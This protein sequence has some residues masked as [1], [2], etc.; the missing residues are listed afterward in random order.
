[1][2][3]RLYIDNFRCFVNFEYRPARRQLILGGNGS[4]KSSLIEALT[5]L[6]R[7]AVRGESVHDMPLLDQRTRWLGQAEQTFE[8]D[9]VLGGSTYT[10]RLVIEPVFDRPRVRSESLRLG[11]KPLLAF[12]G[13]TVRL[14]DPS[15]QFLAY[16]YD[17]YRSALTTVPENANPRLSTFK[18]WIRGLVGFRMNPFAM[19]ALAE[20]SQPNPAFDLSNIAAWY[21]Y[22]EPFPENEALLADLRSALEGFQDIRL[23]QAEGASLLGAV[24]SD[25]DRSASFRFN[26]L[27]EG[28]R[29]LFC[30]YV[31]LH[32]VIAKGNTVIIDEPDNFI[33]LREIQPWLMA[34]SDAVDDGKG[35]VLLISHHPDLI[36]QWAPDYG[37]QFVRDG[38]G[39]VLV[40][41]FSG[42]PEI[43]LSPA[44]L[45]ARGWE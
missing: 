9:V 36:N 38:V 17:S 19:A 24:F 15:D 5:F 3:T 10:Y 35:Q 25:G 7:F 43:P 30:L 13:E 32:F 20:A 45:I 18:H 31:I 41:A 40:E 11:D 1:M 33:S 23:W 8:L 14:Y 44:E 2:L 28:Q 21:K 6:H 16:P 34:V 12:E 22:L 27:S 29:C 39:P 26:E 37:V 42:D 4:G